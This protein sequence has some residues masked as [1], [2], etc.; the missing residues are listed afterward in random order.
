MNV[1][2]PFEEEK[3][4]LPTMLNVLT[5]LTFIG[6]A[7][8]LVSI[9][10]SKFFIGFAK[11]AMEDPATLERMS[12]K[13]VAE[14][15]KGIRVFDLMEANATPLWIV[16]ILGV[17]LCVYGAIQMRKLKKDGFFIYLVGE[18]LPI[19]GFAII[20]GFSNYFSSTSSYISGLGLPLLFVVLYATQLKHMK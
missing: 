13:D 18:I 20:L 8:M 7:F 17:V 11:K 16:T 9:P 4:K 15:E 5:I 1:L 19:I 2:N 12:E 14:M 10:I 6:S 3:K